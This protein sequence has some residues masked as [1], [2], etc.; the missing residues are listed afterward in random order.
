MG[1][2]GRAQID[3]L[4]R[5]DTDE[6]RSRQNVR[7]SA[8][9]SGAATRKS[10]PDMVDPTSTE[11]SRAGGGAPTR[12]EM[13]AYYPTL[14]LAYHV[15]ALPDHGLVY[16]KNPKAACSTVLV[17]LSRLHSGQ[18]DFSPRN[19]HAEHL[20][21]RPAEVGWP[22]ISRM[23]GGRAYRFT[24]VRDPL[25]RLESAYRDKIVRARS[26][27]WRDKVRGSLG[28]PPGSNEPLS[29][30]QFLAALEQQDPATEMDPHW[31][32][33]HVNLMHPLIEYDRIGKVETFDADLAKIREE[34]GVREVPMEKRNVR[35]TADD[36]SM[37]DGRPDLERRVREIFATDFDLYGY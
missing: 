15:H 7:S 34:A 14:S 37:Y 31:R 17:W 16:I 36:D 26:S 28:L 20:L 12:K 1:K 2:T 27:R 11:N 35:R 29:F 19:V 9:V 3:A 22:R 24:F 6:V 10:R 13:K 32:P 30:E 23:L 33:Q 8:R 21:P 4:V 5:L 18:D 25:R